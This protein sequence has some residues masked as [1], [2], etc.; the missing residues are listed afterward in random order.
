MS[1]LRKWRRELSSKIHLLRPRE[2][3]LVREWA[4]LSQH[5]R[6]CDLGCGDGYWTSRFARLSG[7][8]IGIDIDLPSLIRARLYYGHLADF[9]Q[10]S[11]ENLP[12]RDASIDKVVSL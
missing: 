12:F 3:S 8:V 6:V 10:A 11:A 9:V 2:F 5:E 4:R 1:A 7:K